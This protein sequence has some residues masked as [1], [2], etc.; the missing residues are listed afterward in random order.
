[1]ESGFVRPASIKV[2]KGDAALGYSPTARIFARGSCEQAPIALLAK[3]EPNYTPLRVKVRGMSRIFAY[4]EDTHRLPLT[5]ELD[6]LYAG[7]CEPNPVTR[8]V[9]GLDSKPQ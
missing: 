5:S 2:R 7:V 1:M 3:C 9:T 8:S 4:G 6:A